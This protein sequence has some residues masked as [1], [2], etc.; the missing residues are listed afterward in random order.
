MLWTGATFCSADPLKIAYGECV[1]T[2]P[3]GF[4]K[5][6]KEEYFTFLS[7]DFVFKSIAIS[8]SEKPLGFVEESNVEHLQIFK[9]TDF[10][11]FSYVMGVNAPE[12]SASVK[13]D[14]VVLWRQEKSVTFAGMGVESVMSMMTNCSA[15]WSPMSKEE[16]YKMVKYN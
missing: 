7:N 11:V 2:L 3:S 14:F 1:F 5:S 8:G 4:I 16:F 15:D 9:A 10:Y 6:D 12:G 13:M